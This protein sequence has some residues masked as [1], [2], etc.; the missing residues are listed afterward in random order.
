MSIAKAQGV[1]VDEAVL[2]KLLLLERVA[3]ETVYGEVVAAINNDDEGKPRLLKTLEEQAIAGEELTDVPSSTW[4][5][6]FFKEW[7]AMPP[8]LADV[9]MRPAVYVSRDRL[10]LITAADQLSSDAA[11]ILAALLEVKQAT[12]TLKPRIAALS[13][14]ETG[15]LMERLLARARQVQ[16]WGNPPILYACLAVADA[17]PEQGKALAVFLGELSVKQ[18]RPAIVPLIGERPWAAGVFNKWKADNDTLGPVKKAIEQL[19]GDK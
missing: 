7:L 16:E 14:R 6:D 8:Y 19:K 13:R 12:H 9:D 4:S 10:P 2:A 1:A 18:L 17:D 5:S 15:V 11:E 3:D